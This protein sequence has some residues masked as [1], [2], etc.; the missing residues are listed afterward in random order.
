[1]GTSAATS[2]R[3]TASARMS[4]EICSS[5][6]A[7]SNCSTAQSCFSS[8][9]IIFRRCENARLT[10]RTNVGRRDSGNKSRSRRTSVMHAEST[11]GGGKKQPDGILNI[12]FGSKRNCTS[13]D[14]RP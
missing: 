8:F 2:S 1:M 10:I 12:P 11:S 6:I 13:S 4:G 7:A 5:E 9:T 14:S 3:V